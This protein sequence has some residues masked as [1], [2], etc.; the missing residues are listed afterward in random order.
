MKQK[1]LFICEGQLGDLL[2]LTP[3]LREMKHTF[4]D[5]ELSVMI[6]QRRYYYSSES[7]NQNVLN[8]VL[9]KGTSEVLQH[10]PFVD[11]IIEVNRSAFHK[12]KYIARLKAEW[13]VIK[14]LRNKKYNTVIC[15]FPE[16]RFVLWSYLSAI[17]I[18]VG[19][20]KQGLSW[21]LN[22]KPDISKEENGVLNYYCDLAVAAGAKIDSFETNYYVSEKSTEWAEEFFIKN[23]ISKGEK[24]ICIHPGASGN[25]KIWPP[26][27]FAEVYDNLM[28]RDNYAALL[29]GTNFDDQVI[30][31][32]KKHIKTKLISVDFSD[33]IDRFAAILKKSSLCIS[34]D[35]GPRHLA[36][37]VGTPAISIMSR[38]K[39]K[40]WKI[41]NDEKNIIL[42][43]ENQCD[44]CPDNDCREI[45]PDKEIFGAKC[46]RTIKVNEVLNCAMML[47]NI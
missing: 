18:R 12:L 15:T 28:S 40:A 7:D 31:E 29:C 16:D 32:I 19:Q 38:M 45:I 42:Q 30:T 35:S 41:Y 26:E 10:N 11:K 24:I 39:H 33:S 47:L 37:A 8:T 36:V 22:N 44:N 14:H 17:K 27:K 9:G 23:N 4:P 1:I 34:N 25:Y 46:I 2:I 43:A 20:K 6:V 13:E 3:A 5:S 21:L